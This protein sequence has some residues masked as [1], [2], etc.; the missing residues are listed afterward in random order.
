MCFVCSH[1]IC[2]PT[3]LCNVVCSRQV[4]WFAS[5]F[6]LQQWVCASVGCIVFSAVAWATWCLGNSAAVSRVSETCILLSM[7]HCT[8]SSH[9]TPAHPT[10]A[11]TDCSP[12]RCVGWLQQS[13]WLCSF[14]SSQG[15]GRPE[16][17]STCKHSSL[18]SSCLSPSVCTRHKSHMICLEPVP[19]RGL[20]AIKR[21]AFVSCCC[22]MLY[23]SPVLGG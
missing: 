10:T 12:D 14:L 13:T 5:I 4:L 3:F 1:M 9:D 20:H 2:E 16:R 11:V 21:P 19:V 22:M 17:V 18:M 23:A 8:H 15:L 7:S 6:A